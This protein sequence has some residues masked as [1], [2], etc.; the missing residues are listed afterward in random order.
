MP[1]VLL[2]ALAALLA[3]RLA[4][5]RLQHVAEAGIRVPALAVA[6]LLLQLASVYVAGAD[7]IMLASFVLLTVFAALNLHRSG[8]AVLGLGVLLNFTV[9]AVNGGMP[10]S[11][12]ALVKAGDAAQIP[13]LEAGVGGA[14]WHLAGPE[15]VLLPLADVVVIPPPIG[16]VVSVGD[17]LVD[18]GLAWF[19]YAAMR[20]RGRPEREPEDDDEAA[21][22]E[23][24]GRP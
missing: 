8:F 22:A 7:A 17:L 14:K 13:Q 24:A 1:S 2:V 6:G 4:G 16:E 21:G 23:R 18:A 3:G 5:G 9:V 20:P 10:I 19:L 12:E 11:P 15:D